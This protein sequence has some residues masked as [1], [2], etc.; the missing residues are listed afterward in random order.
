MTSS[1]PEAEFKFLGGKTFHFFRVRETL[2]D[3]P[4]PRIRWEDVRTWQPLVEAAVHFNEVLSSAQQRLGAQKPA[5]SAGPT[6][7]VMEPAVSDPNLPTEVSQPVVTVRGA[8]LDSQGV[9]AV[10]VNGV[11]AQLRSSGDIKAMEFS[12]EGVA[13]QEG[14]NRVTVVATN[15]DHQSTQLVIPLWLRS[16][17]PPAPAPAQSN[18]PAPAQ[19]SA[20]AQEATAAPTPPAAPPAASPAPTSRPAPKIISGE[21]VTV[22]VFSEPIGADIMLDGDFV[23]NTPSILKVRPGTH[24]LNLQLPGFKPWGQSLS[25]EPG[26]KLTTMRA[27]LE[28]TE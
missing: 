15:V 22:E 21:P 10:T 5:T 4:H 27:T 26:G 19:S 7:R 3:E 20:P 23:G 13:L 17:A 2:V 6:V 8:A 12:V 9:L 28:K 16:A 14:L 24:Y 11:A 18:A 25:L 1:L